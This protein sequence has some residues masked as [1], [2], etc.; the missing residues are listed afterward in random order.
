MS[1]YIHG[2]SDREFTRLVEQASLLAPYV[3]GGIDYSRT[4]E[5]LELGC[6]VGAELKLMLERWPHLKLTGVD[7]SEAHLGRAERY[8]SH[9]TG[10]GRVRLVR[11]DA[12]RLPFPDHSF[13]AVVTI[14]LLEHVPDPLAVIREARRV[15]RPSGRI[16]LTEVEN[17]TLEFVPEVPELRDWWDCFNR[18]Q[19]SAGGDPFIG[20]RLENLCREAGF[21]RVRVEPLPIIDSRRNPDERATW[22]HYL[23]DLML[24]GA[25]SI[26]SA[27]FATAAQADGVKAA[28]ARIEKD[29]LVSFRYKAAR[30]SGRD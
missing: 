9:E 18:F 30:V 25:D 1:T 11:A 29:N 12:T 24:S 16:I 19:I 5:L 6:A 20:H 23:R 17:S 14:W 21:S 13:D 8:L 10:A 4:G 2:Y 7:L 27:R 15:L 22:L 28:F 3:F 26:I